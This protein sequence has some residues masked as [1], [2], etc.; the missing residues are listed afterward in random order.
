MLFYRTHIEEVVCNPI[1]Q[2]VDLFI[3]VLCNDF[4][5]KRTWFN[6]R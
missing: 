3:G 4:K 2:N 6:A 5:K 1:V